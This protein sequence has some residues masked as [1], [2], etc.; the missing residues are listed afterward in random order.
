MKLF[1]EHGVPTEALEALVADIDDDV[2]I[3]IKALVKRGV[4]NTTLRAVEQAVT[5]SIAV[6]FGT[7][8]LMNSVKKRKQRKG[9]NN[10]T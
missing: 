9:G 3:L 7:S 1:N 10:A 5:E 6:A 4:D 2:K 8:R